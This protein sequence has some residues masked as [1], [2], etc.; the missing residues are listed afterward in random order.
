MVF[1]IKANIIDSTTD[2]TVASWDSITA[3]WYQDVNDKLG[4][5]SVSSGGNVG[6]WASSPGAKLEIMQSANDVG[7]S[8]KTV[9]NPWANNSWESYQW[10]LQIAWTFP[11]WDNP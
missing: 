6:I 2:P 11:L 3:S 7:L 1:K 4:D 9:A 5:I 8:I 10:R